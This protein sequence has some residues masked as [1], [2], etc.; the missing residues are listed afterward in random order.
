MT[1]AAGARCASLTA[2]GIG[3]L[4]RAVPTVGRSPFPRGDRTLQVVTWNCRNALA[5][6]G[7]WDYFLELDPD[8]A[9]LQ[10]VRSISERIQ[11][12]YSMVNQ[13]PPPGYHS[14]SSARQNDEITY[15]F[16]SL[17]NPL[18]FHRPQ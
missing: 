11:R 1:G 15:F 13:L 14:P 18:D 10:E 16:S 5:A 9:F 4:R 6:S 7:I 2:G 3:A 12:E 17:L 8:V